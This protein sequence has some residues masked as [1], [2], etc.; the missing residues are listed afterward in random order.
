VSSLAIR[1]Q[2]DQARTA[3]ATV[4]TIGEAVNVRAFAESVRYA[5]RQAKAG[6][7][8]QNEAAEIR[9]RAER[10][11]G[12]LLDQ[13]L[14]GPGNPLWSHDA[15]IGLADV[16]VTKSQSSRYQQVAEIPEPTFEDY[17]VAKKDGGEEITTAELLRSGRAPTRNVANAALRAIEG[18]SNLTRPSREVQEIIERLR[19]ANE[20]AWYYESFGSDPYGGVFHAER[21]ERQLRRLAAKGIKLTD[22][23]ADRVAAALH[24]AATVLE[25][26]RAGRD[27]VDDDRPE[28]P[29]A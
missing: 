16:G 13:Q 29:S 1:T 6:M 27:T 9:L 2:L 24:D 12:E 3:L 8:A 21:A 19:K 28:A 11:A 14:R 7:D 20:A 5:A 18:R 17:I 15:T 23:H 10:R 26:V 25:S 22:D 4:E